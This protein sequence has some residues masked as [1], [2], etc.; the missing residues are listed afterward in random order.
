MHCQN[1]HW[2]KLDEASEHLNSD[3]VCCLKSSKVLPPLKN[4]SFKYSCPP[5]YHDPI[6]P[7]ESKDEFTNG[8]ASCGGRS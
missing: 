1:L 4:L 8:I 2:Y 6:S 7:P 3:D 5:V